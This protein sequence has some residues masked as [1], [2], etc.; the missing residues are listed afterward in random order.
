MQGGESEQR[1]A[2]WA[3]GAGGRSGLIPGRI[4]CSGVGRRLPWAAVLPLE[5]AAFVCSSL[6]YVGETDDRKGK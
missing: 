1:R 3:L 2:P 4:L 5:K 6:G